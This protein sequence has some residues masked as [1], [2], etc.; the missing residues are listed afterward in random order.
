MARTSTREPQYRAL[1]DQRDRFGL[2]AMGLMS[3][4]SWRDDPRRLG[5]VLAR[6]KFVAKMF[7]GFDRVLEIGCGDGFFSRVV[8]QEVGHLTAIDFDPIF[9]A[10]AKSRPTGKRPID[11]RVHDLM[12]GPIAGRYDGAYALDVLEHVSPRR[13]HRF[14]GHLA[15]SLTSSGAAVIGMPSL[16]SQAHASPQSKEGHVNCQSLPD[17]K[18]TLAR[19]FRH[20][21]VFT[22]N[23]ET[24]G[25][26][27]HKMAHYLLALCCDPLVGRK[28]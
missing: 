17:L 18:R 7:S 22:M 19:H 21:F 20:V 8:R 5:F 1:L 27:Y 24:L 2:E 13:Q 28:T 9:I 14:L 11:Y 10:D 6:Y 12:R 16:E 15:R 3:S 25:T 26:G 23:D 4:Q